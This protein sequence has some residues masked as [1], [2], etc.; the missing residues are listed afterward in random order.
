MATQAVELSLDGRRTAAGAVEVG[1]ED[2]HA[3]LRLAYP[4]AGATHLLLRSAWLERLAF[5]HRQ[6]VRLEG[7]DGTVVAERLLSA[8]APTF[9][10]ILATTAPLRSGYFRLGIVYALAGWE[11]LLVLAT[12]LALSPRV[13]DGV[14]AAGAFTISQALALALAGLGWAPIPVAAGHA[15]AAVALAAA[16]A[17]ALAGGAPVRALFVLTI[18]LGS[19]HGSGLAG[20]VRAAAADG[21]LAFS[22]GVAAA[23]LGAASLALPLLRGRGRALRF[24]P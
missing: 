11:P 9:E 14:R 12:V 16:G 23:Q 1:F 7:A 3:L 17:V 15:V 19:T 24:S 4:R 22:G 6:L 2:G 18:A 20:A 10:A 13:M 8:G 5:G 21:V